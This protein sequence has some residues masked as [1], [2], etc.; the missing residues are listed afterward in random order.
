MGNNDDTAVLDVRIGGRYHYNT[1]YI[2]EC[3]GREYEFVRD[4]QIQR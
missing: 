4:W 3:G 1:I 2:K